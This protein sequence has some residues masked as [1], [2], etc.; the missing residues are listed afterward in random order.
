MGRFFNQIP[1]KKKKKQQQQQ[2]VFWEQCRKSVSSTILKYM[3][4]YKI[5][6]SKEK[7]KKTN[8]W[9]K[10]D[11]DLSF[12]FSMSMLF[13]LMWDFHRNVHFR[14]LQHNF[15]WFFF[16]F[17]SFP[18][19]LISNVWLSRV[20]LLTSRV[21]GNFRS[22]WKIQTFSAFCFTNKPTQHQ[23]W[24]SILYTHTSIDIHKLCTLQRVFIN[25]QLTK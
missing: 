7:N 25:I 12:S 24:N 6:Y 13:F 4:T 18:Q 22:P 5:Y 14:R 23:S 8:L 11:S 9:E 15:R 16:S 19:P 20:I 17:S 10:A 21:F 2:N 1:Y 3:T